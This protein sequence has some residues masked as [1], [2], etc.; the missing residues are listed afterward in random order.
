MSRYFD[1]AGERHGSLTVLHVDSDRTTP[2]HRYWRVR[3]DCGEEITVTYTNMKNR[4][5]LSCGCKTGLRRKPPVMHGL[6]RSAE[7]QAWWHIKDR[8][9]NPKATNYP[10]YGGRG[11][12]IV[13]EWLNNF[14]AFYDDIGPRPSPDHSLD[15]IDVN[16]N[17]EPGNVRWATATEQARNRRNNIFA[18]I[19]GET[20]SLPEWCELLSVHHGTVYTRIHQ[21]G[22]SPERA[23][24]TPIRSYSAATR[25]PS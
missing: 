22:W 7:Y 13:D 20:K 16:G 25:C 10:R 14:Q 4:K 9:Y 2:E 8:C 18:T 3:C 19:N 17:Y 21:R 11:I 6:A 1:H 23:L 15:R 5:D 24:L 12:T